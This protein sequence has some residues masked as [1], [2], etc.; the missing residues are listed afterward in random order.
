VSRELGESSL[1][2][3][4]CSAF[5][6]R[7]RR[8]RD[9]KRGPMGSDTREGHGVLARS[10]ERTAR[11]GV[12]PTRCA[13]GPHLPRGPAVAGEACLEVGLARKNRLAAVVAKR[14]RPAGVSGLARKLDRRAFFLFKLF[15][16]AFLFC[17]L[18]FTNSFAKLI[19]S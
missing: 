16:K 17:F 4:F 9:D 7:R 10:E 14:G 15:F 12:G 18:S 1:A 2:E 5:A 3:R 13:T 8:G 6:K 19:T 11:G